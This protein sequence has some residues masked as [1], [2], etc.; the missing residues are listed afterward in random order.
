MK[1]KKTISITK[2][3]RPDTLFVVLTSSDVP[4]QM[5]CKK[6]I[7]VAQNK[8]KSRHPG[9]P[10]T[11]WTCSRLAGWRMLPHHRRQPNKTALGCD[12]YASRQSDINQLWRKSVRCSWTLSLELS[13]NG[14]QTADLLL[15][16]P[17]YIPFYLSRKATEQHEPVLTA[18][19]KCFYR[20]PWIP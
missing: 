2:I 9:P 5:H 3:C 18:L 6:W 12:L 7:H 8:L 13:A 17:I 11:V 15:Y 1:N 14:P 16:T 10:G 4:V 19:K 20:L